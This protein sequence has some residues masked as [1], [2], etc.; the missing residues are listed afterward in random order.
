MRNPLP[1]PIITAPQDASS[2]P[3]FRTPATLRLRQTLSDFATGVAIVTAR[4]PDGTL[5][6]LTVNSFASLSLEPPLV[7]WSL[8]HG[9]ASQPVFDVASHYVVNILGE[10]Q[11][12][13]SQRFSGRRDDKFRGLRLRS[14]AG[15]A[16]RIPGCV[17]W[18]ECRI[19][20]RLVTGDHIILIGGV[21]RFGR[22]RGHPPPLLFHHG[23]Y[24]AVGEAF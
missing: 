17:A 13:L 24:K 7:L 23:R 6:G 5:A 14:G 21:E 22:A 16:P 4:A 9:S 10:H 12:D 19:E 8:M 18:L 15:G 1:A 20:S 3:R 2:S 11:R